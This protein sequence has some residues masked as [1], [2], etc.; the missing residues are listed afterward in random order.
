MAQHDADAHAKL[1][2]ILAAQERH[3]AK[4]A[5]V[6]TVLTM[7][8]QAVRGLGEPLQM[9]HEGL[10]QLAEAAQA[11]G[12]GERL[13]AVLRG[14]L[15]ELEKQTGHMVA[16]GAGL[17]RLPAIMEDTAI[18]AAGMAA[19]GAQRQPRMNGSGG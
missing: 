11:D 12:D 2:R 6:E 10:V 3:T 4:L 5:D 9:L 1:D 15:D 8:V 17:E 13:G 19:A 7:V 14:I 18:A 16:I